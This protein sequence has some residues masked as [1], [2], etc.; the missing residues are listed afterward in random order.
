M[1]LE[2]YSTVVRRHWRPVLAG[3][4]LPALAALLY[5]LI[6]PRLYEATATVSVVTARREAAA[7]PGATATARA[8]FDSRSLASRIID[9]FELQTR[10]PSIT[11]AIFLQDVLRVDEVRGTNF[12]RVNIRL[13][14]PEL[15]A[16]V[17][18]RVC[19]VT[20]EA[21]RSVV[22]SEETFERDALKARLDAA[23]AS[24]RE[25]QEKLISAR[26]AAPSAAPEQRAHL[27]QLLLEIQAEKATLREAQVQIGSLPAAARDLPDG[28]DSTGDLRGTLQAQMSV[29]R[30]RIAAL[31]RQRE[32]L[33]NRTKGDHPGP[34]AQDELHKGEI[35][36]SQLEAEYEALRAIYADLAKRYHLARIEIIGREHELGATGAALEV[37]DPAVTPT[38]PV[39]PR[40]GRII[41]LALLGGLVLSLVGIF[42]RD[43]LG[44]GAT[45]ERIAVGPSVLRGEE[46]LRDPRLR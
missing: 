18:N 28:G 35:V 44:Q 12:L 6:A 15:A 31:E 16:R 1:E 23:E 33:V 45:G 38:R 37:V 39:V 40:P 25:V 10:D 42:A 21:N 13:K 29:S 9:E 34:A 27:S 22:N 46:R 17:A 11:P 8:L 30:S 26:A 3:I 2:H 5:I 32:A 24:L 20:A 7:A 41:A 14:D 4:A 36:I 43:A 19:E